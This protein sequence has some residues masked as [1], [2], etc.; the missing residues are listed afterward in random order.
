MGKI[1]YLL[2]FVFIG[3][4]FFLL[5]TQKVLAAESD[6]LVDSNVVIN[7]VMAN[8]PTPET[9]LEWVE[10]Y[11]KGTTS[12]NLNN[13]TFDNKTITDAAA[14][15]LPKDF[16]ILARDKTA[17]K[18]HWPAV[19]APVVEIS[20]ILANPADAIVLT[21]EDGTYTETFTWTTDPGDNI[22]WE[23]I[24][25]LIS[26]DD[27]WQ[28]SYVKGGTPGTPNSKLIIPEYPPE[29]LALVDLENA[30]IRTVS[31]TSVIDGDTIKVSGLSDLSSYVRLL[32][33]DCPESS[34]S[35]YLPAKDYTAQ[36]LQGKSVD[37][38][39]SKSEDEQFDPFGRTLAIIIFQNKVFNIEL[40]ERGLA[41]F[42][43]TDNFVLKNAAWQAIE[44]KARAERIGLWASTG[45]SVIL[46]ELLPNPL[47]T[48]NEGEW[49]ELYNPL[50][51]PVNLSYF[52]LEDYL[53][54]YGT[55]I[56]A[57]SWLV[58][59]RPQTGIALNNTGDS[60]KLFFPDGLLADETNFS[61]GEEGWTWAWFNNLWQWTTKAT[62]AKANVIVPPEIGGD[63]ENIVEEED[64]P[65]NSE[66]IEIKTGE[67]RNYENY[68]VK[69]TGTVVETSGNTFYIDDGTGRAKIYI[70]AA[71]G[72]EKPEMHKGDI[73]E[74]TGIVNLYRDTW[75]I[76]PRN[77]EDIKLIQAVG[78]ISS[79]ST[80]TASSKAAAPKSSST[81]T[82]TSSVASKAKSGK[83]VASAGD[84]LPQVKASKSSFWLQLVKVLTA[85][86][87]VLLVIFFIRL[88][89]LKKERPVEESFGD[90]FT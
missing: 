48:D 78:K 66:P 12:V 87:M 10:L 85:L 36:T 90:D 44:E 20:M 13:W 17:F 40:M 22:S 62:P 43:D 76:L 3:F 73:F 27:N 37:L 2:L 67:I 5:G 63:E 4:I 86:G 53:I 33:V 56:P 46:S 61:E 88:W 82:K 72:I 7:E 81:T 25:P 14:V 79:S 50:A 74:I 1:K 6:P 77:L 68:L 29:V 18:E 38:I 60:V 59:Y 31:V 64:I 21:N 51:S 35:M 30:M 24:D 28:K 16:L 11:N 19:I 84:I 75:R 15:I 49:V 54:P 57:K 45:E 32:A 83:Q 52:L 41:S 55:V 42:Y 65:L 69:I 71:T 23:K 9:G 8:A 47:G 26:S 70:Q 58:F 80:K 34:E 89:K 39:I